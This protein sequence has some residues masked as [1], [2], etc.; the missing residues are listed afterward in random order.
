MLLAISEFY[1]S[2]QMYDQ[3]M[4]DAL[5]AA[6][7]QLEMCSEKT[8]KNPP[9]IAWTVWKRVHVLLSCVVLSVLLQS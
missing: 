6:A 2:V 1:L 7:G 5:L 4:I 9:Q 8:K 3:L